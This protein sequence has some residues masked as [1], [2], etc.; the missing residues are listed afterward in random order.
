MKNR[1]TSTAFVVAMISAIGV[2]A[3]PRSI[4]DANQVS[5]VPAARATNTMKYV[6]S[7]VTAGGTECSSDMWHPEMWN[8]IQE[9]EKENPDDVDKVPIQAHHF[10]GTVILPTKVTALR[11]PDHPKQQSD[12][13]DHVQRVQSGQPPVEDHEELDLRRKL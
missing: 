9:R 6:L 4:V 10:D 12:A 13:D 8:Q 11:P 2:F 7:G 3:Q 5:R 1:M